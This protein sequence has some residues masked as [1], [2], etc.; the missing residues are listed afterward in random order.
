[1]MA[2]CARPCGVENLISGKAATAASIAFVLSA[3]LLSDA[4]ALAFVIR[5]VSS[6]S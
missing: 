6:R 5:T 1:M 3:A 2:R 4:A